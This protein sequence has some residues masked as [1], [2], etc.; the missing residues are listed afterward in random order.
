M[1]G[2]CGGLAIDGGGVG[3]MCGISMFGFMNSKFMT[4]G[5]CVIR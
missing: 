3:G 4:S 1:G 5:T 2:M